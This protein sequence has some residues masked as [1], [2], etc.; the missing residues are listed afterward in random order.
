MKLNNF[1]KKQ[2]MMSIATLLGLHI[3]IWILRENLKFGD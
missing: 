1:F 2:T 3:K